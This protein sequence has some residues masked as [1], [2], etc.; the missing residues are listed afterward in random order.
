MCGGFELAAVFN[1]EFFTAP[2]LAKVAG[3][4]G[5]SFATFFFL[6]FFFS[7]FG[8]ED[9][10]T[11]VTSPDSPLP[12]LTTED[13]VAPLGEVVLPARVIPVAFGGLDFGPTNLLAGRAVT[14]LDI[15]T[16]GLL[17][18]DCTTP[19]VT[20]TMGF[21]DCATITGFVVWSLVNCLA[22][23]LVAAVVARLGLL[24]NCTTFFS[25]SFAF[26][27]VLR[28]SSLSRKATSSFGSLGMDL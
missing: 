19:T 15:A 21:A 17:L 25:N 22:V 1:V 10:P 6:S 23:T 2:K 18:T 20:G 5:E 7:V 27:S 9:V 12:V 26:S 24:A 28:L 4:D 13:C 11:R 16:R 14:E 3:S 8:G